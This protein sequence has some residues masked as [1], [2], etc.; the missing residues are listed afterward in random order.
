MFLK[1]ILLPWKN[2]VF[3]FYTRGDIT[4]MPFF[5]QAYRGLR[6]CTFLI[7]NVS[8][9]VPSSNLQEFSLFYACTS[10][11][12][13][14]ARCAYASNVVGKISTHLHLEPFLILAFILLIVDRRLLLLLLYYHY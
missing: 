14:P 10:K 12:H 9:C 8:L 13:C 5:V 4:L 1:I 2:L 11:K 6:F 3:I 7:E